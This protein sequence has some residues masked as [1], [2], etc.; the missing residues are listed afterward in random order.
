M[1]PPHPFQSFQNYSERVLDLSPIDDVQMRETG[2]NVGINPKLRHK[3]S[4]R[5]PKTKGYHDFEQCPGNFVTGTRPHSRHLSNL[6]LQ[7]GPRGSGV[8]ADEADGPESYKRLPPCLIKPEI[9]NLR[10]N[11]ESLKGLGLYSGSIYFCLNI[12]D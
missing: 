9:I 7:S 5:N 1:E 11:R 3:L 12:R 4:P 6:N 10:V 8:T 2:K